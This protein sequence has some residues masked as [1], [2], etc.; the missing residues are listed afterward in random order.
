MAYGVG[1]KALRRLCE[2]GDAFTWRNHKLS[3]ELFSVNERPAFLWADEHLKTF[4]ALPKVDTLAQMFPDVAQVQALEPVAYYVKLLEDSFCYGRINQANID[5]Q[6]L[7]KA[8]Q[9]DHDSALDVLRKAIKDIEQQRYRTR[10]LDVGKDGAKVVLGAYHNLKSLE[11][12]SIFGWPYMDDQ[13][14]PGQPGEVISIVGRPA[15]GKTWLALWVAL[16]NWL[17][18]QAVLLVSMEMAQL[19]ILQR[20]AAVYTS[21]NVTQMKVGGYSKQTYTKF[22]GGLTGMTQEKGKLYV[23]DGNLATNVEEVY[24]LADQLGCR[25]VVIDGA[26]LVRS[27]NPRLDRY[28]RVAENVETMKRYSGELQAC[29]FSSWQLN[30]DAV[31][32]NKTG[33]KTEANLEDIGYSDAIGQISA[34]VLGLLQED[35]IETMLKRK[36]RVLKGRNGEIGEFEIAWDFQGMDFGQ[37]TPAINSQEQENLELQWL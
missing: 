29:T 33:L 34:V 32:K 9:A 10:V 24:A 6:N 23:I 28:Q 31:K 25:T 1:W 17:K 16:K 4:H 11:E 26:Y 3:P 13:A 21:C 7:L 30:R 35:G 19:A 14:G 20:V 18:G 37:V 8:D 12:L 27:R 2:E 36:V 5:S 22:V 15:A